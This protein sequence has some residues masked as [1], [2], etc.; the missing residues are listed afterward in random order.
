LGS[1]CHDEP[2]TQR[3]FAMR[4]FFGLPSPVVSLKNFPRDVLL[5]QQDFKLPGQSDL[6]L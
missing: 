2:L 3:T 4:C 1:G 6:K 5:G